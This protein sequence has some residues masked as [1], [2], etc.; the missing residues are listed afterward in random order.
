MNVRL[1]VEHKIVL[2]LS[3]VHVIEPEARDYVMKK[4]VAAAEHALA[5]AGN[6]DGIVM[7][8]WK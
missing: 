6:P 3:S 8:E 2:F 4:V 5:Q 1:S 7:G